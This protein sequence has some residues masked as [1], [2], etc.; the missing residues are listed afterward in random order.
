MIGGF[1]VCDLCG[2]VLVCGRFLCIPLLPLSGSFPFGASLICFPF[3]FSFQD[4]P[5]RFFSRSLLSSLSF[6][7]KSTK[8][9]GEAVSS[10][11]CISSDANVCPRIGGYERLEAP[12]ENGVG[13]CCCAL[14][15][16]FLSDFQGCLTCSCIMLMTLNDTRARSFFRS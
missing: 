14:A 4:T 7:P 2:I 11:R 1:P 9:P 12:T 13:D 5:N 8:H 16:E 15:I 3:L 10:S 6:L